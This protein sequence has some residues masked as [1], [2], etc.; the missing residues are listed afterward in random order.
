MRATSIIAEKTG[1]PPGIYTEK[2]QLYFYL[3]RFLL[4]RMS[5]LCRDLRSVVREGDGRVKI[6]FSRRGGMSY[7]DFQAIWS[8]SR[9]IRPYAY[10][11]P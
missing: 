3:T 4:E 5:W 7:T 6:I 10:T 2:N 8:D 1:I 11:G 9:V